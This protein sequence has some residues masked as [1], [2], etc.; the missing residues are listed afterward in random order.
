MR[1]FNQTAHGVEPVLKLDHTQ[2]TVC[3]WW[4][5]PRGAKT[6]R[7]M[8]LPTSDSLAKTLTTDRTTI[9]QKGGLFEVCL[10]VCRG[11]VSILFTWEFDMQ[12]SLYGETS[13]K[14]D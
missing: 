6:V 2:W 4:C 10:K 8:G 3:H 9:V 11:S 14:T 7:K 5:S 13:C 1:T 12:L